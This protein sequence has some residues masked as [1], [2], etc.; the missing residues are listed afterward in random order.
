MLIVVAC[1]VNLLEQ[2]AVILNVFYAPS[3][4]FAA[5]LVFVLAFIFYITM[6]ITDSKKTIVKL[7]QEVGLL[8]KKVEEYEREK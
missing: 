4:F 8:K 3:L 2:L 5:A 1:N 6:F 7:T